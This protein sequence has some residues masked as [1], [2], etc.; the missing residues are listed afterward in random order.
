MP[1]KF[2]R[3][4]ASVWVVLPEATAMPGQLHR[5]TRW[6]SASPW[7]SGDILILTVISVSVRDPERQM[8]M[9][10]YNLWVSRQESW[11]YPIQI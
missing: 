5:A 4:H 1:G 7:G 6:F 3:F 11:N 9:P 2:P 8:G 10:V